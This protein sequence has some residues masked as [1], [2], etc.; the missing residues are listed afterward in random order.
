[1]NQK[2]L[3]AVVA[4]AAAAVAVAAVGA[5]AAAGGSTACAAQLLEDWYDG[6]IDGVYGVECY[7][8]ALD[9]LPEDVRAYSSASDDITRA[10]HGRLGARSIGGGKNR[11]KSAAPAPAA[12]EESRWRSLPLPLLS[13]LS[14][15]L[16]LAA[17]A[18]ARAFL[19]RRA[20]R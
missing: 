13:V 8:D 4:V 20:A 3:Y 17:A 6:R 1:M 11:Q 2:T 5:P 18:S 9:S 10:L 16:A 12:V 15:A 7:R 19:A 14:V